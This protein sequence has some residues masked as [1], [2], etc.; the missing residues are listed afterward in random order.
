MRLLRSGLLQDSRKV[1]PEGGQLL[2]T[3]GRRLDLFFLPYK[4]FTFASPKL[5]A[6]I[7]IDDISWRSKQT[8]SRIG[9]WRKQS[10]ALTAPHAKRAL[11]G[12]D[13]DRAKS[14]R[15]QAF[16]HLHLLRS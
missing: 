10:R 14:R 7:A 13:R 1:L 12:R 2:K 5:H 9:N 11:V 16:Q 8:Q 15:K 6:E 3:L 4:D